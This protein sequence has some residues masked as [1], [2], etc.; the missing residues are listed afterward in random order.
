MGKHSRPNMFGAS[1]IRSELVGLI[2]LIAG[3]LSM[4]TLAHAEFSRPF[5][6]EL[7]LTG[8]PTGLPG[9]EVPFGGKVSCI[10][11]DT[12]EGGKSSGNVWVGAGGIAYEFS[13]TGEFL[14]ELTGL[15]TNGCAFDYINKELYTVGRNEW[16]ATDDSTNPD[17]TGD[18]YFAR[19]GILTVPGGVSRENIKGEPIDF[20][21]LEKDAKEYIHGNQLIGRPGEKGGAVEPWY[22]EDVEGVAVDSGS[23]PDAGYIYV[24]NNKSFNDLEVDEFTPEGCFVGAITGIVKVGGETK[25]LFSHRLTGV[26]VDPTDGDVLAVTIFGDAVNEFAPSG[27]YLGK[28]TG[29]SKNFQFE[30]GAFGGGGIAV[31]LN[32]DLYVGV[33]QRGKV[34]ENKVD[35]F[36]PGAFYPDAV[37]GGVTKTSPTA[38]T[39]NGDARGV[40]NSELKDLVL[41]ECEFEYVTEEAFQK[42]ISEGKN[43]FSN[44]TPD[45]EA[46]CA[47][48]LVGERLK[49][50]NYPV[51][52]DIAGLDS[53]KVYRYRLVTGT[54]P[55]ELEHG[56]LDEEGAVESFAA[57]AAP[58]VESAS[59]DDVSSS[60][61]DFH[62]VIDPVGADTTYQFEYVTG[63]A[64]EKGGFGDLS[65]G[66][67]VPVTAADI[68]SGDTGV[69]VNVQAGHLSAGTLYHFRVVAENAIGA[70]PG[71]P[72]TEGAFATLPTAVEGLPNDRAYEMMTPPNKEDSEDLFGGLGGASGAEVENY[73]RGFSSEDGD[74]FLLHTAAA[75]GSFPASGE[76]F[77]VF[78]R[79][80][81]G[82]SVQTSVSPTLGVQSLTDAVYDSADFSMIGATDHLGAVA[83]DSPDADLVGPPGGPYVTIASGT[84]DDPVNVVGASSD[85]SHLVVETQGHELPTCESQ[86]QTLAKTLDE[87]SI[88]L[89]EWSAER[90]CLSLVDV[91]SQS[92]GGGLISRCGAVLGLGSEFGGE[93]HDAV[94]ADGSR[95]VFT[96]PDPEG[97]G[98]GCWNGSN[99]VPQLYMHMDGET[100][101]V[102]AP[103][104]GVSPKVTYPA[105]Y[106][107]ASLDGSKV[108]FLTKTE[109]TR[110]AEK[111]GTTKPELYEYNANGDEEAKNWWE[112]KLV[113]ISGGEAE[114]AV[115]NVLDVPEA[116]ADGST[117]YFNAEGEL[118]PQ[119]HG[120]LYRYDTDTGKTTYVLPPQGYPTSHSE[121]GAPGETELGGRWYRHELTAEE[122]PGLWVDANWYTTHDGRFLIFPSSSDVT[123]YDPNGQRELYRYD[124]ED[125][126]TVCV[127]CNPNGSKPFNGAAFTHSGLDSDNP[128]GMPPRPISEN[129]EYVFFD[130]AESLVPGDTNGKIDVYEWHAGTI[131]LITT[132]QDTND[133]FFLDSGSYANAEGEV[134][135]GGN[136]FFGTHAKLVPADTDS[137]GDL[138]DAR[139]GGGFPSPIGVGPCEGDA[140][141]TPPPAP[142]D[143]TQTLL[144][145]LGVSMS[146]AAPPPAPP[147]KAAKKVVRCKKGRRLSN[148]KCVKSRAHGKARKATGSTVRAGR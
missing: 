112:R 79:G 4:S 125:Q 103:E 50:E 100:T 120:G 123:G 135:E 10:A 87:K 137:Q 147:R 101:E 55:G 61:A 116:S 71:G 37:T 12:G 46:Q 58:K 96:A 121:Y 70:A 143:P 113:R 30:E 74:H 122:T 67:S 62:A 15:R 110:S 136:V 108:F 48:R 54:M 2:I 142:I 95:V 145:S 124:A 24:I 84:S 63:Q 134:V 106:V 16:V 23:G 36:G 28:I 40:E 64:F 85:L 76:D 38:V 5:I 91:K 53:G 13:S 19:Q 114:G 132:G 60:W 140:C 98:N 42:S 3:F 82:W 7:T 90:Q 22:E 127:S 118:T 6:P 25:E 49:E 35:V 80:L 81:D 104:R 129:G 47:P 44:L 27:A 66:G 141:Q 107:G 128:A 146:E 99:N 9:E 73:D 138:Y 31:N 41:T 39:L 119:A 52:A 20:T 17:T 130:T 57:P 86:Q 45:D 11:I 77:D 21:C 65:S 88:G 105:V 18:I 26:A 102:S 72:D 131:S 56:G 148:G 83:S 68:G 43:G 78:T 139:I 69:S 93:S 8:T 115:G 32:G 133:S 75:F 14:N 1:R 126:S 92:E 97:V 33:R 51:H 34:E 117:V 59:V 144:P 111:L 29:T 89:Y 94:S 109:L